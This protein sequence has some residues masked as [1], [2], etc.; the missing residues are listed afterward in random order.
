M[1]RKT[2]IQQLLNR[3]ISGDYSRSDY[4]QLTELFAQ[5]NDEQLRSKMQ[6]HWTA[7]PA[8][9]PL[10]DRLQ[11]MLAKFKA[12][13]QPPSGRRIVRLLHYYQ[14]VAAILLIPLLLG[15]GIWFLQPKSVETDAMATLHSPEGAR[16]EFELPDGTTGWL[17]SGSSISFPVTFANTREVS[18][19]GEAY[20][21]VTRREGRKF[22]V[23]TKELTVQVL[24]TAF[25]VAAYDDDPEVQVVLKEGSVQ[26]FDPVQREGYL[27]KPDEAF[28]YDLTQ[29]KTTVRQVNAAEL[30]SWT[31]GILRFKKEPL[32]EVMEKLA[33]WYNAEIQVTDPQLQDYNF[34]ATF[35]NEQ[36]E[37]ILEMIALTTPM[38]Y[39]IED[40]KLNTHGI[41]MKKKVIIERN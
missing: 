12:Q 11:R 5:E 4:R 6:D 2:P 22:R 34:T 25:N 18:L 21:E 1:E 35:Q 40:R 26:V 13:H 10:P 17:N 37:D 24:G 31:E 33:H 7:I 16:T 41:Y 8:D 39:R 32:S 36:L 27:M 9:Q 3:L 14:K 38:K 30:T 23:K 20:F 28:S 19:T 15:I 29:K